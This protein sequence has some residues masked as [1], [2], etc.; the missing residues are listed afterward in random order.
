VNPGFVRP[1]LLERLARWREALIGVAV[2]CFGLW[3]AWDAFGFHRWLGIALIV[4]GAA[5]AWEGVRR[6]RFRPGTGGPGLVEVDER[7]ITYFGPE[8]GGA[9]SID[10]L[11][12]VTILTTDAGPAT[13]D[14]HWLFEEEGG[15]ALAI[16]ANAAGADKLFDAIAALP[17]AD[18]EAVL[19]AMGTTVRERHLVWEK[20]HR[21]LH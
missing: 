20:A 7:Q 10:A 3:W 13:D 21:R 14:V 15:P 19:R 9:V 18:Y 5:I 6:A 1:E 4:A 16:P 12:R 11:A 2:F 17:G 8:T